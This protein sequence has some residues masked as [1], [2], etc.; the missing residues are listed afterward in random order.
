[1]H[2]NDGR[3][4]S[5][6]IMQALRG[7]PITIYGDGTQTRSFGFV[8]DLIAGVLKLMSTE[9]GF[10]GPVNLGNPNEVSVRELAELVI[11][12]TGSRSQLVFKTLPSDDPKQ[13][14]PD[15]SLARAKLGWE[16]K[17]DLRDGLQRSI[18]YFKS[19]N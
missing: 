19:I 12:M 2:P 15:I 18:D 3:V 11:A 4:I 6:F 10:L 17:V 16:P 14:Q 7:E 9:D 1:M 5:N 8:D 13:R